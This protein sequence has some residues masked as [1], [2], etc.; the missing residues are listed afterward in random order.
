[1]SFPAGRRGASAPSVRTNRCRTGRPAGAKPSS[2]QETNPTPPR[3][4]PGARSSLA[5]G[6]E[7]L[8]RCRDTTRRPR[9][10]GSLLSGR[11]P[12]RAPLPHPGPLVRPRPLGS[13]PPLKKAWSPAVLA[14][15]GN[16][17]RAHL[18]SPRP[19]HLTLTSASTY[20]PTNWL[21][22]RRFTSWRIAPITGF[23]SR[24]CS[25]LS[26]GQQVQAPT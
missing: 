22:S 15:S 20:D 1:M 9:P 7:D 17:L 14:A 23:P 24:A 3:T 4:G 2:N 11:I 19:P 8:P 25:W 26:P 6:A 5:S 18:R 13:E 10:P 21:R 12:P 16:R